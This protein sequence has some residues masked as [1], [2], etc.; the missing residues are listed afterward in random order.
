[1]RIRGEHGAG[2]SV[3]EGAL[4]RVV[5]P[6]ESRRACL[7]LHGFTGYPGEMYPVFDA[8]G[9]EGF[10]V[11]LPRYPGHA[12]TGRDFRQTL[13]PDWYGRAYD[14]Y[15]DLSAR[16]DDVSIVGLSMGGL[17]ATLLAS[18]L[19]VRRLVLLAPA[20]AVAQRLFYFSEFF[21]WLPPYR[22]ATEEEADPT[23]RYLAQEY[24]SYRFPRQTASLRRALRMGR[25]AIT[26]VS[27]P[28]LT[29]TSRGDRTVP[30]DVAAFVARSVGASH[31]REVVLD[32]SG[33]VVTLGVERER[34][35][36]EMVAWLTE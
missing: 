13:F 12:T 29:I 19:P 24:W 23:R 7:V 32:L 15:L 35:I 14:A 27:V 20:L 26:E 31:H 6:E 34:V 18:R 3:P 28:T 30:A 17:I 10:A 2:F 36:G 16:Y 33:H 21:A 11:S 8:L 1:M 9:A 25:R 5:L 4:P 22:T